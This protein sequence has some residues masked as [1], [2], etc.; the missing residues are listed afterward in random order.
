[1]FK[2]GIPD[3]RIGFRGVVLTFG[4]TVLTTAYA[5]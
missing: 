2:A 5:V 4:L 3:L 1:M